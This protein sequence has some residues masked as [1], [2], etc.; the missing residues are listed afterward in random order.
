LL[1]DNDKLARPLR[2]A[3]DHLDTEIEKLHQEAVIA[4]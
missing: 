4:A 2:L 3:L 1:P